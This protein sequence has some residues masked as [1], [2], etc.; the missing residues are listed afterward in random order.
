MRISFISK[1][2]LKVTRV[3]V[4]ATMVRHEEYKFMFHHFVLF[5]FF[6]WYLI[7]VDMAEISHVNRQENSSR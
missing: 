4:K 6:F 3:P 7:P 5:V 1:V 2:E